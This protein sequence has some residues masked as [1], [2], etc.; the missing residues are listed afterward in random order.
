MHAMSKK[1]SPME[2][3]CMKC[4]ILFSLKNK[5]TISVCHLI[6]LDKAL[7]STKKYLY[8]SY[9]L[10]KTYVVGTHLKRH[11]EVLLISTHHIYFRSVIRKLF[12]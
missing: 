5:K 11:G 4:Q 1:L 2:T 12:T 10:K 8:F 9:F 7:F 3:I 6:A